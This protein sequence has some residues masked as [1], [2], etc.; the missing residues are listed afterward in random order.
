MVQKAILL[1]RAKGGISAVLH[2]FAPDA[3]AKRLKFAF[4]FDSAFFPS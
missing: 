4:D 2:C 1:Q 3:H